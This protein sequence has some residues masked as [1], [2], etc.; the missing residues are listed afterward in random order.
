[1]PEGIFQTN[2]DNLESGIISILTLYMKC[3]VID[4]F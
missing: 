2:Y 4:G 3:Q 1:M